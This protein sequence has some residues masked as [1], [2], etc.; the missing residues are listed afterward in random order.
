MKKKYRVELK[1]ENRG[2]DFLCYASMSFGFM[3]KNI[4]VESG[5]G[6]TEQKAILEA[7]NYTIKRLKQKLTHK[8]KTAYINAETLEYEIS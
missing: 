1:I 6:D 3:Y 8:K 2:D 5:T 4:V 7:M